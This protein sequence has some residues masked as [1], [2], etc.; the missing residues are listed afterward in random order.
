MKDTTDADDLFVSLFQAYSTR[1]AMTLLTNDLTLLLR[2]NLLGA[3]SDK[4]VAAGQ[5]AHRPSGSLPWLA[6]SNHFEPPPD[7]HLAVP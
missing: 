3:A 7:T 6:T 4:P 2:I 5:R 1:Y